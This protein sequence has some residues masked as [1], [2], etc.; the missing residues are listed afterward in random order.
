LGVWRFIGDLGTAGGPLVIA[1]VGGM[2]SLAAGSVAVGLIGLAGIPLITLGVPE[3]FR[4]PK[5]AE[6]P[7]R[8]PRNWTESRT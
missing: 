8:H 2:A 7:H 1:A 4:R 6:P 3:T 5:G